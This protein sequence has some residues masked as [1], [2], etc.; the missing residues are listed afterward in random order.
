MK[1]K[2]DESKSQFDRIV[3]ERKKHY[4]DYFSDEDKA[5]V[6]DVCKRFLKYDLGYGLPFAP[7]AKTQ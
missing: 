6:H 4:A 1:D 7:D 5:F 2:P 3:N